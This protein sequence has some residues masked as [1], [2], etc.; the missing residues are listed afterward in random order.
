MDRLV[1]QSNARKCNLQIC[2]ATR[3]RI[4]VTLGHV[5]TRADVA[6]VIAH[7]L[8]VAR[9]E[10]GDDFIDAWGLGYRAGW[11]QGYADGTST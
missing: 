3:I 7:T 2:Q 10:K 1:L 5:F 4:M 8:D 6:E 9:S 11:D